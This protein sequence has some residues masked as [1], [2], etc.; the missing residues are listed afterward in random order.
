MNVFTHN[1]IRLT[2]YLAHEINSSL[3]NTKYCTGIAL[4]YLCISKYKTPTAYIRR[5]DLTEGFLRYEFKG[6]LI[7]GGSYFPNFTVLVGKSVS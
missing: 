3:G 5:G 7:F 4:F 6:P 2:P 1:R